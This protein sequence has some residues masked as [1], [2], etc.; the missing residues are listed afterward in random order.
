[1][2]KYKD[3]KKK[4]I[5]SDVENVEKIVKNLKEAGA[6]VVPFQHISESP[7]LNAFV[8]QA[9]NR[10]SKDT[11]LRKLPS[12]ATLQNYLSIYANNI[13]KPFVVMRLD[14]TYDAGNPKSVLRPI[15][16]SK[17]GEKKQ[18]FKLIVLVVHRSVY[19]YMLD[20]GSS[21]ITC[22][23]LAI[24]DDFYDGLYVAWITPHEPCGLSTS[25]NA[26]LEFCKRFAKLLHLSYVYLYDGSH[27]KCADGIDI[28][29]RV[30][31]LLR[32]GSS[33]YEDHGFTLVS[34]IGKKSKQN[35]ELMMEYHK[36]LHD[37]RH[38]K[39][40]SYKK[41]FGTDNAALIQTHTT[42]QLLVHAYDVS[43]NALHCRLFVELVRVLEERVKSGRRFF[44]F[45]EK[46]K[47]HVAKVDA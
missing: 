30:L 28:S 31:R 9:I 25:G 22:L 20:D 13:V 4:T 6:R 7:Y 36:L 27:I 44:E 32:N 47:L 29:L 46:H 24:T 3:S 16:S 11:N 23:E 26:I 21:I 18:V 38:T 8:F 37:V 34:I 45:I 35:T 15:D 43:Y 1:M 41:Y 5:V 39:L 19:M 33:W 17:S 40:S 12:H 2:K 10:L 14:L 42:V